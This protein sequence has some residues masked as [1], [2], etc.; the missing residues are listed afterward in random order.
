MAKQKLKYY[1]YLGTFA[2]DNKP[3]NIKKNECYIYNTDPAGYP[4]QH[5][6]A[7][8]GKYSYDSFG[9]ISPYPI[10]NNFIKSDDEPEQK[11][12]ENNCGY[13]AISFIL[14]SD[15]YG[16]EQVSKIL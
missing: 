16:V 12:Y 5:W 9:K 11:I 8:C 2:R 1:K 3:K 10:D 15:I 4:G 6:I 13:R 7:V 14:T